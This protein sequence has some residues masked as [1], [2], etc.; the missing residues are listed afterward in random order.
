MKGK[1]QMKSYYNL[2]R[3]INALS[4]RQGLMV[5]EVAEAYHPLHPYPLNEEEQE[6]QKLFERREAA[7][8]T[9]MDIAIA[10]DAVSSGISWVKLAD[11]EAKIEM[12]ITEALNTVKTA[13]LEGRKLEAWCEI[14][15]N[16]SFRFCLDAD[17]YGEN[18][19]E[20]HLNGLWSTEGAAWTADQVLGTWHVRE[21]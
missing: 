6:E 17:T 16:W 13:A 8:K 9:L 12:N 3:A 19:W 4:Y 20:T 7:I 14:D 18:P 1:T 11:R 21:L 10:R 5:G 2:A 15:D